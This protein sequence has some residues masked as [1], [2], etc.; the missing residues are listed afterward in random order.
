[1]KKAT[2]SVEAN[3]EF[4][5]SVVQQLGRFWGINSIL[6]DFGTLRFCAKTFRSN[7]TSFEKASSAVFDSL[8][9]FGLLDATTLSELR[10]AEPNEVEGR[11]DSIKEALVNEHDEAFESL[12]SNEASVAKA[13]SWMEA[14]CRFDPL[15]W[16]GVIWNGFKN[17]EAI[18]RLRIYRDNKSELPYI[19]YPEVAYKA[20]NI[21]HYELA[22]GLCHGTPDRYVLEFERSF[23]DDLA[24]IISDWESY[25]ASDY[26]NFTSMPEF[27]SPQPFHVCFS[28]WLWS[29]IPRFRTRFRP[30]LDRLFPLL[31]RFIL[32]NGTLWLPE[33]RTTA[34]NEE[35][36]R[37]DHAPSANL[38]A[39]CLLTNA[40]FALEREDWVEKYALRACE[41][42]ANKRNSDG[43]WK[44]DVL[45]SMDKEGVLATCLSI[46]ALQRSGE[47]KFAHDIRR[48]RDRLLELQTD[49]GA[50]ETEFVDASLI[51]RKIINHYSVA[52]PPW[53][54][55]TVGKLDR[56]GR[57]FVQIAKQL[58]EQ[59]GD[60]NVKMSIVAL[61]HGLE[62]QLYA[63]L[64][65]HEVSVSVFRRE[66]QQ[67]IGAR[68]AIAKLREHLVEK[69]ELREGST[70]KYQSQLSLM[71][72]TRDSV[73]HKNA[74]VSKSDVVQWITEV[75]AFARYHLKRR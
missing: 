55:S 7:R 72:S 67:T 22:I 59:G 63:L 73:V 31:F 6:R 26:A 30:E 38:L 37:K 66:G 58:V 68:D 70:L 74:S 65:T 14:E 45:V 23:Q 44:D 27:V 47:A 64:S 8:E 39:T 34:A 9:R 46:E 53:D 69:G 56:S 29:D 54:N 25:H 10:S 71:I 41:W 3:E 19:K 57:E 1:V 51:T 5:E 50:W 2:T 17:E 40:L 32:P 60:A 4:D 42:I 33:P 16:E 49:S 15:P 24:S 13:C 11:L 52:A 36:I 62:F 43:G 21:S 12:Q 28:L 75:E 35:S 20:R 18:S 61:A 48:G